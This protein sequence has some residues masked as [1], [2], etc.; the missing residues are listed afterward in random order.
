MLEFT[1]SDTIKDDATTGLQELQELLVQ[2]DKFQM[3]GL[4]EFCGHEIA[5]KLS[6]ENAFDALKVSAASNADT[7]KGD[8]LSFIVDK[9]A[10]DNV[11]MTQLVQSIGPND[12]W[13]SQLIFNQ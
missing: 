1:Y 13:L 5:S 4:K 10:G 3:D 7:V 6:T 8:V 9:Q 2:S 11:E 12:A